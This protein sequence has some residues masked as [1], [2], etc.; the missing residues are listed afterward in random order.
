VGTI[1][2]VAVV[3]GPLSGPLIDRFGARVSALDSGVLLAAGYAVLAF[4]P[5]P[6][7]AF[8][9]AGQAGVGNGALNP[10]QSAL[11]ARLS[12]PDGS[13]CATKVSRVATNAGFGLG[14]ALGGVVAAIGLQGFVAL[15]LLNAATC[16]IYV[17]ILGVVVRESA[18]PAPI[19]GGYRVVLRDA[20]FMH[21]ALANVAMMAVGWGVFSWLIPAF[22]RN[23]LGISERL[24]GVLLPANALTVVVAQMPIAR[25]AEGQRRVV[26][27]AV[28]GVIFAVA[29]VLG[30]VAQLSPAATVAMLV[31]SAVLVGVGDCFHDRPFA[32]RCR[33]PAGL[34]ARALHGRH[35]TLVV[36]G[37]DHRAGRGRWAAEHRAG[38]VVHRFGRRRCHRRTGPAGA[39]APPAGSDPDDT[40]SDLTQMVVGV[41]RNRVRHPHRGSR[42]WRGVGR[43]G[44]RYV[45]A[46][47]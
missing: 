35:R 13:H 31:A 43:G 17:R 44:T 9:G 8:A 41:H 45:S 46:P 20:A 21:L 24:I 26:L 19:A 15:F 3:T 32:P 18:R 47:V 10:S 23:N 2:G 29:C 34:R 40:A 12:P 16:L 22:A 42:E 33:P 37:P 27:M 1:T 36:G 7:L 38:G 28:A 25:L 6:E 14:G 5:A 4:A 30:V 11:I 39:R